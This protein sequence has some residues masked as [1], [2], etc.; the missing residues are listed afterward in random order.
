MMKLEISIYAEGKPIK[1]T[2]PVQSEEEAKARWVHIMRN[3]LYVAS[4]R[5]FYAP[6]QIISARLVVG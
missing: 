6:S 1:V 3:G 4:E 5:C 2:E